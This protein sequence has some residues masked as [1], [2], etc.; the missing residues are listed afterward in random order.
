MTAIFEFLF[1]YRPLLYE[2][3]TIAFDPLWPSYVTWLLVAGAVAGSFVLYRKAAGTL[4]RSWRYGL[5][6]LRAGAFLTLIFLFLQPVLRVHSAIPQK[7]FVA[8]AY[9]LSKSMEIRDGGEGRSRLEIERELLRH[10]DNPLLQELAAKFKLRFFRFAKTAERTEGFSDAPRHGNST[11]LENTLNQIAAELSAAPL[12]GIVLFTDGAD[13]HSTDLDAAAARLRTRGVPV[14]SIGVGS[15]DFSRDIEILRVTAPRQVFKDTAVEAEVSVRSAGYAG[16]KTRLRVYDGEKPLQ[17]QEISLGSDNEVKTY[18]IAFDVPSSGP[19]VFRFRAEPFA[20]ET[21]VENNDQTV[22]ISASDERPQ[23]LYVEGEPR[24]EFAFLRRAVLQDKNLRLMTLLRQADGKFLRQ[25]DESPATLEKGFPIDKTE[26]FAYKAI[27]LG[28]VEASFFTFDQLRMISDFVS[29]RG[30]GFLMLGGR[31]SFGQGG[32]ANTPLQDLLPVNLGPGSDGVAEFQDLEFK[33]R[34]TSYGFQHPITRISLSEEQN[35][36]RWETA[37]ALVGLNPT[38]GPKAGATVLVRGSVADARGQGPVLLAFQRFGRGKSIA[39]TTAAT[40]RWRMGLEHAD[41][42]HETFW[43]QM[44]RWM[45][46]DVPDAVSVAAER[47]SYAMEDAAVIRLDAK[48]PAFMPL[49]NAQV[50]AE[51]KAPSGEVNSLAFVWDVEKDGVYSA[52]FKSREEGIHEVTAEASQNGKS[53]GT[54]KTHFRIAES[55]AEF[56][57]A[58]MNPDLL[59]RLA[60]G[61]GGRYYSPGDLLNLPEDISYVEK[62]PARLEEKDLWDMPFLFL[63]LAGLV[64]TEWILRKRKGLA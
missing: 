55:A 45:V 62:G 39:W 32:Y 40:W 58:A 34:L 17:T 9:D 19:R 13:N 10:K 35:R 27:I 12:A 47:D 52:S 46:S 43:K 49:N 21:I 6:G 11:D 16:R 33:A 53:L 20:D 60:A 51:V 22:L 59:K 2:R 28:S 56:H 30:G 36:K 24:W 57:N 26:L 7:N 50:T 23:V 37:P 64:S 41:N 61:T 42:F 1:K 38:T 18:K 48:D 44:L 14:Y 63:L 54:A 8:I 15:S 4:P 25:G 5:S 29:Q 3:G 31:H